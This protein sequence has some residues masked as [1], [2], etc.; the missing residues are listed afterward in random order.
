MHFLFDEEQLRF[1]DSVRGVLE[2]VCAP[3]AV[4]EV[5]ESAPAHDPARWRALAELG[6]LGLLAPERA[7]GLGLDEV[8]LVLPL[9]ETGRAALPEA[10][11]E[12]AL[13]AVPLLAA[14]A[15]RALADPWLERVAAGDAV[16]TI[17][18]EPNP[19]ISHADV[20]GL[21]LLAR[22][23]EIHALP[24]ADV[25]CER[26]PHLDGAQRLFRVDATPSARTRVAAGAEAAMLLGPAVDRGA[27]GA[28][29]QLLGVGQRLIEEAVR[30]G[31]QREQFGRAIGS[32][33]AIKHMLA[34]A[35]VKL[36]FARPVVYR[37]AFSVAK[38]LPTRGRDVSHAK[39]VAAEAAAVA[40]RTALQ[41]H[42]AIGYTWEV[43]L[44]IWMKRAWALEAS[45]GTSGWHRARVAAAV[46][47]QEEVQP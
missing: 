43:D 24:A 28:A 25:R 22:A 38:N 10:V 2:R 30:Y 45:W 3:A 35:Q 20:A 5:W 37:A 16:V 44:H 11:V 23:G 32:F 14:L 13:V 29:A 42:G 33:Q 40:A 18:C 31:K 39:V 12:S 8:S 27:L 36:E 26:L 46:L 47:D 21:V 9:E 1:R 19:W 34:S 41:V 4:R 15:D 17:G 6:V 7:G